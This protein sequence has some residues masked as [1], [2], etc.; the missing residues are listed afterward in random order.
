MLLLR[1]PRQR[2]PPLRSR[3]YRDCNATSAAAAAARPLNVY[4]V[5]CSSH[6]NAANGVRVHRKKLSM[7]TA[8]PRSNARLLDAFE[9]CRRGEP[10]VIRSLK[11]A[12]GLVGEQS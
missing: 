4:A 5:A 3:V 10:F 1:R 11:Y 12:L 6:E 9:A 7:T 8:M 2:V